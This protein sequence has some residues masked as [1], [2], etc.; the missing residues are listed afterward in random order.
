MS[1]PHDLLVRHT[2]SQPRHAE[3]ALRAALPAELVKEVEWESLKLESGSV[4]DGG[5]KERQSDL[6]FSVRLKSGEPVLGWCGW[7]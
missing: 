6:L 3:A 2:F 1:G 5:L 7:R 4:V